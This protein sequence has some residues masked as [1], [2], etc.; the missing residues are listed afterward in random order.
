MWDYLAG[1]QDFFCKDLELAFRSHFFEDIRLNLFFK[2]LWR[3]SGLSKLKF[4]QMRASENGHLRHRGNAAKDSKA[5]DV[6]LL[7]KWANCANEHENGAVTPRDLGSCYANEQLPIDKTAGGR[8]Q[9]AHHWPI[10]TSFQYSPLFADLCKSIFTND[11]ASV[12][13]VS[14]SAKSKTEKPNLINKQIM[15]WIQIWILIQ[16]GSGNLMTGRSERKT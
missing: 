12:I 5:C 14:D 3:S 10:T 6:I 1:L 13:S 16:I 2:W 9:R 11:N 8:G 7:C 4:M 15:L